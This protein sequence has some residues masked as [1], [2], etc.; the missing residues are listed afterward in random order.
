MVYILT[1]TNTVLKTDVRPQECQPGDSCAT[2]ILHLKLKKTLS[3]DIFLEQQKYLDISA[4]ASFTSLNKLNQRSRFRAGLNLIEPTGQYFNFNH[5][6]SSCGLGYALALFE[7][8]WEVALNKP[9][10]INFPVFATG[11]ILPSGHLNPINHLGD[12]IEN[13]CLFIEKSEFSEKGFYICY[14]EQNHDEVTKDLRNR[15]S[16]LGGILLPVTRLQNLLFNL[17]GENYDGDPLGRW[18]PFKGLSSFE[19]EDRL[20]FFGRDNEVQRLSLDLQQNNGLLIV[21][22]ASGVGKSSIIKAGLIPLLE[23]ENNDLYWAY[24]TPAQLEKPIGILEYILS[25][26]SIAWDIS[27]LRDEISGL[28]TLFESDHEYVLNYLFNLV[29]K[30]SC[31]VVIHLD[32]F[33]EVFSRFDNMPSKSLSFIELLA[34]KLPKLNIVLTIRNEYLSRLFDDQ[35][36]RSPIISNIGSTLSI[37]S[38]FSIVH[39]QAAFSGITFEKNREKGDLAKVIITEASL[40]EYALPMVEFL[41]DQLYLRASKDGFNATELQFKHYEEVNGLQGSIAFRA[42]QVLQLSGATKTIAARLFEK[43]VSLDS[44][45]V[46][47]SRRVDLRLLSKDDPDLYALVQS[48]IEANLIV[49]EDMEDVITARFAHESLFSTWQ[50]LADWVSINKI[51]LVWRYSV[52]GYLRHW[53]RCSRSKAALLDDRR[54][55]KDGKKFLKRGTVL[56]F[57]LKSY[58]AQSLKKQLT[59]HVKV[60]S[61]FVLL[62]LFFL[63]IYIWDQQR[64][65][66]YYYAA[67]GER[68]GV[69]FGLSELSELQREHLESY[70]KFEYRRNKLKLLSHQNS[71]GTL[72]SDEDRDGFA[73]WSFSYTENGKLLSIRNRD[74]TGKVKREDSIVFSGSREALITLGNMFGE[75]SS[76]LRLRNIHAG[77]NNEVRKIGWH[78]NNEGLITRLSYLNPFNKNVI[79]PKTGAA[80]FEFTYNDI[81]LIETKKYIDKE[82]KQSLH[83]GVS[84]VIF[85]YDEAFQIKSKS[86]VNQQRGLLQKV[87]KY[88]DWGN[89]IG[90]SFTNVEGKLVSGPRGYATVSME[91]NNE[92]N[93][94]EIKYYDELREPTKNELGFHSQVIRYDE[95][96][97]VEKVNFY[98]EQGTP[99]YIRAE[100]VEGVT[101]FS[102]GYDGAGN[103]VKLT[104]LDYNGAPILTQYGFSQIHML[105]DG[106]G[107]QVEERYLDT[108]GHLAAVNNEFAILRYKYNKKGQQT[109]IS[110]FTANDEPIVNYNGFHKVIFSF[111]DVGNGTGYEYYGLLGEPLTDKDGIWKVQYIFDDFNRPSKTIGFNPD[112]STRVIYKNDDSGNLEETTYF[113]K[114][115]QRVID[116]RFKFSKVRNRYDDFGNITEISYFDINDKAINSIFGFARQINEYDVTGSYLKRRLT[117]SAS[118]ALFDP[119]SKKIRDSIS[120]EQKEKEASEF[121]VFLKLANSGKEPTFFIIGHYYLAGIGTHVDVANAR[122]WFRRS[123]ENRASN[124]VDALLRMGDS[125][126]FG[127]DGI[128]DYEEAIKWYKKA[129][130]LGEPVAMERLGQYY[131]QGLGTQKNSKKAMEW[132]EKSMELGNENAKRYLNQELKNS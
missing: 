91:R 62:P 107:N 63:S 41:L 77:K 49:S 125:Y 1:N 80:G 18:T 43:F 120:A 105:F 24:A 66:T 4:L 90:H 75:V 118:G 119:I 121:E 83:S 5:G 37:D 127:N 92:R 51:Y 86:F 47:F 55:L 52:D 33:E 88:D 35:A 29:D 64:V 94:L 34:I 99:A 38:W 101:S 73:Q 79:E 74:T 132:L 39:E 26:V 10:R 76:N 53:N 85:D 70:Y 97:R 84:K 124:Y 27:E 129:A 60:I 96:G 71:A 8:W 78:F 22:G 67:L 17:L 21:S 81:G 68:W 56:D 45:F 117:Y 95:Y 93:L 69:P 122:K 25:H 100:G 61:T 19:Y 13:A 2:A 44:D 111:D 103:K 14:P 15:V 108:Q 89:D 65:K 31:H 11:E 7:C 130:A 20:R 128:S 116:E 87:Y 59:S 40:T 104:F 131:F 3:H 57:E 126:S 46:P 72:I 36:I 28:L 23:K 16:S 6:S 9:G 110:S 32:Q 113:D 98:T 114:F 106:S 109:E 82:G 12:K 58:I 30:N 48:F 115:G 112:G 123:I 42:T 54:L 50:Q 102:Y